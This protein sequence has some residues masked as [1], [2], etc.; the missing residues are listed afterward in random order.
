MSNFSRDKSAT[1]IRKP[2]AVQVILWG[3]H[4]SL[5]EGV[6]AAGPAA[7]QIQAADFLRNCASTARKQVPESFSWAAVMCR[8]PQSSLEFP[9]DQNSPLC[10]IHEAMKNRLMRP[11]HNSVGTTARCSQRQKNCSSQQSQFSPGD[12]ELKDSAPPSL[13]SPLLGRRKANMYYVT[14]ESLLQFPNL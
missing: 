8:V 4:A 13:L 10:F 7:V 11:T 1:S 2:K 14:K 5:T 12:S 9:F 6:G 3:Q